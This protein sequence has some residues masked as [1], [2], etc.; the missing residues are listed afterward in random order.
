MAVRSLANSADLAP[1]LTMFERPQERLAVAVPLWRRATSEA[2]VLD[3]VGGLADVTLTANEIRNDRRL[4]QLRARLER[5]PAATQLAVLTPGDITAL[6]PHVAV[7]TRG[8]Y[9]ADVR[10]AAL[11]FLGAFCL[12]H[13][14]RRWRGAQDDPVVLPVLMMLSG[15]GLMSMIALR[16]P[17]RDTLTAA[18]FVNGMVGGLA[19]LV[20][21]S[22]IDFEASPLRRAVLAP[23]ALALTLATLL[24]LFGSGPGTS[25]VKV[26]LFGVQ[27]VEA[28]RL[29][30]VFAL[31]AYFAGR[32]DLLRELSEP[33]TE[34]RPWLR[35]VRV[36]R[37]KDVRPVVISMAL[38][39]A[40]FFLQKDLGPALV[41]SCVVMALYA[42]ARGRTAFVFAGFA[43][44]FAGF[45]VA[46]WIGQPATVG[47]RVAI[48][49]NPWNNGV[50]GGNQIAHGL[51]ALSTGSLWGAGPG[52]GR[53]A[54]IPAGH[55]DFVL[56]AIGEELGFVGVAM[57]VALYALLSWRCLRVAA[58]APGDYTAFLATGVAL[59]L[60][61]QAFVIGAG[62]LGLVPLAGVVTPFISFGRSSMLANCVAVG[63]V[64]AIARRRGPVRPQLARPIGV[65][66][67]VLAGF[68]VAVIGRAAWVQVVRADTFATASS[69]SEQADGGYRFEYNPRLIAAARQI[70]RGTVYDRRG[71]ILATSRPQE[72][73]AVDADYRKSGLAR[74]RGCEPTETRCY[75]LGGVT[76]S[77]LGD[78]DRQTN[79]AARN[80][81]FLERDSDAIL[82]G[83]DDHQRVVEV[84]NPRTGARERTIKRDYSELLPLVRHGAGSRRAGVSTLLARPRDLRSSIDAR[85]QVRAANALRNGIVRG[86]Y[87]R[88]AA[89]VLDVDT[90]E[91]LASV[92]YPWPTSSAGPAT[93]GDTEATDALL[94]RAR[95][96]LYPPGSTFKLLVAGAALRSVPAAQS[97]TFACMRLPDGRVGNFVKGWT[98]PVRD[99]PMD[100]KPHG[101]VDLRH[102]LVVSCNAYFAQL[103]MRLGP[104]P[105]LDA[106]SLFQIEA[107]R[108][109]TA[110]ALKRT[111]A[112]AGYGQADVLV[113]PLKMARVAS[114]IAAKGMVVPVQ[115]T[116]GEQPSD[117]PE[118]STAK[119][120]RQRFLSEGDAATLSR[121]MR[122][123]VTA[124]TGRALAAN[125]SSIAGKTGTA[126]VDDGRAHSWFAGYAPYGGARKIAFAVIVENAGY[127]AKS[128]API[129]GDIVNAARELNL[130]K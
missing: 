81:S 4:T 34:Q 18:G 43:M 62:L 15:I 120:A 7:R 103:A 51:W 116:M 44:L 63:I 83:F 39:L 36:P 72:I 23:L 104:Q 84:V 30:V 110:A 25:G 59:A 119:D 90:G 101:D 46:Y 73:A 87:A 86:G 60:V 78:W 47:Q 70:E 99:D 130:I 85:L 57:V 91:V 79:W 77:V 122:E 12:A 11:W 97:Q 89:V 69:L 61:V 76:F 28:I 6:K 31:A 27:P 128:A 71:L 124:G 75:P 105:I 8:E 107:A 49:L 37:W 3:H 126:E 106:A 14:I 68:M 21:V 42:I 41:L 66:G 115:W 65:L 80:S 13:L 123:A 125:P 26:N 45:T 109:A 55:T 117:E 111:L 52:L 108:P 20:A 64:L 93:A 92:S 100:T 9:I 53:A 38:V 29:L 16:D 121:Y 33:P 74:E 1:L 10:R 48:W 98:R 54:S 2:P 17:L 35:Y 58:R 94:D 95:Y 114:S 88:G 127:G 40:F 113:S 118:P 50:P 32:L 96:G 102:G 19:L 56:A 5:R 112:H 82:K 22:E 129:A 24:L 67:A